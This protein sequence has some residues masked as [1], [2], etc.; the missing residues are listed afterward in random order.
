[1]REGDEKSLNDICFVVKNRFSFG[2]WTML[3]FYHKVGVNIKKKLIHV[4]DYFSQ[5]KNSSIVMFYAFRNSN[6]ISFNFYTCNLVSIDVNHNSSVDF[7]KMCNLYRYHI[8]TSVFSFC[9]K[10]FKLHVPL[11]TARNRLLSLLLLPN[12]YHIC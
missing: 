4:S 3:S 10:Y 6:A 5:I 11:F 7:I 9:S 1:M 8:K 2:F 12:H